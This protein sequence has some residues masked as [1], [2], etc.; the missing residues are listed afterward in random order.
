MTPRLQCHSPRRVVADNS[1]ELHS[2]KVWRSKLGRSEVLSFA[3]SSCP[4]NR[5]VAAAVLRVAGI[6][7][8]RRYA[9]AI[10]TTRGARL[11]RE[12]SEEVS[13]YF[14]SVLLCSRS[15]LDFKVESMTP[16]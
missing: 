9:L 1:I 5:R 14:P 3:R 4:Q 13:Y 2:H 8:S 16:M 12:P 7:G 15:T 11:R 10:V 6:S